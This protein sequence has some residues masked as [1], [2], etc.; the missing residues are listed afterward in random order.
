MCIRDR[1]VLCV[2]SLGIGLLWVEPYYEQT[3]ANL[4]LDVTGE[5]PAVDCAV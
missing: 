4:F 3:F 5:L 1:L 2:L